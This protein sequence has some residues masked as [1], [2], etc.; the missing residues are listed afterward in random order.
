METFVAIGR[1][2]TACGERYIF[3]ACKGENWVSL[4]SHDKGLVRLM[5]VEGKSWDNL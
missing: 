5:D 2:T 4:D 3:A 1:D